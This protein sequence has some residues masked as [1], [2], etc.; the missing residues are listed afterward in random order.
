MRLYHG[1]LAGLDVGGIL[2]PGPSHVEDGCPICQAR[3][4][5]RKFTVR[6]GRAWALAIGG[7]PGRRL[8]EIL[9]GAPDHALIDPPSELK[10]VFVTSDIRYATWYA[11]RSRGDVYRVEPLGPLTPS[12]TDHFP[13]WSTP[14]ARVL[15]VIRRDVA[16]GR[17]ERREI[18]RAWSRADRRAANSR[19]RSEHRQEG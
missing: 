19:A 13:A 10:A 8:W 11:A 4:A 14:A 17:R 7:L 5:G 1:G 18:G 3:A 12:E 16:L 15:V 6:E 2:R 9:A